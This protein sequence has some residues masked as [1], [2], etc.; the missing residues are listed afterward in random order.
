VRLYPVRSNQFWQATKPGVMRRTNSF[1]K[2]PTLDLSFIGQSNFPSLK[3]LP[4]V[5][6]AKWHEIPTQVAYGISAWLANSMSI[7][8]PHT[9][10][11]MARCSWS[12]RGENKTFPVKS[13]IRMQPILQISAGYDQPRPRIISGA[14]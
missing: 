11:I 6:S 8:R 3:Y 9:A 4:S 1:F 7:S 2:S 13:S 12:S 14:L 5:Q 10:C